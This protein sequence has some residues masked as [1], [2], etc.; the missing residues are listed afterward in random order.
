MTSAQS[1]APPAAGG[2]ATAP[3]AV[4]AELRITGPDR[5]LLRS[6]ALDLTATVGSHVRRRAGADPDRPAVVQGD[7]TLTYAELDAWADGAAAA[8]RS[9]GCAPGER[10]LVA[11]G[12]GPGTLV[13]FLALE[14]IGALYVPLDA[15]WSPGR[16]AEVAAR[17][18]ATRVLTHGTWPDPSVFGAAGLTHHELTPPTDPYGTDGAGVDGPR[19]AEPRTSVPADEPRYALYTAEF[20]GGTEGAVTAHAGM[21]N[22]LWAKA[23]DLELHEDDRVAFSAPVVFD[24][25]LWQ[26]LAPLLAGATVVVL[27]EADTGFPRRLAG[28]LDRSRTT[29]VELVPETL[30]WLL[31][32][33]E[34]RGAERPC[35]ALR[36]I[37]GTGGEL[38]PALAARTRSVLPRARLIYANGPVECSDDVLHHVVREG[39][40]AGPDRLPRGRPIANAVI[41]VLLPGPDGTWRHAEPGEQGELFVRGVPVGPGYLDDPAATARCFLRDIS[42]GASPTGLAFRT[43]DLASLREGTVYHHGRVDRRILTDGHEVAP[44][45]LELAMERLPGVRRAAVIPRAAVEENGNA[46][47]APRLTA[48]YTPDGQ[49]SPPDESTALAGLPGGHLVARPWVRLTAMPLTRKGE[50]DHRALDAHRD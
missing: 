7:T 40:M 33:L 27:T 15:T 9:S 18:G 31:G 23:A 20:A 37:I 42:D 21:M 22:H 16:I 17:T 28:A 14:R 46:P 44:E 25:A 4:P 34:R 3:A 36:W 26:M 19:R 6:R 30:R 41:S 43:G 50:I 1:A 35:A 12:R 29:V 13:A 32:E 49:Q 48:F 2:T 11:G 39:D 47:S 45:D 24:T 8:L 5:S 38:A 10:V